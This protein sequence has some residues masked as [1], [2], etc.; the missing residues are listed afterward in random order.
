TTSPPNRGDGPTSSGWLQ[1]FQLLPLILLFIFS[2]SSSFFNSP[3][4]QYPTFSLQRHPPYT[5]QRFTHSLQI[6]YFVNPNDFNMLE[7]N[8]RI[9]RRYE[10]TVETSYVKQ[11]QQLCN[12]E[13]IL[14][15]RKLNEALGWYFNLDER[16]LEEAKEMKMPNCEK[17]NELAEIVGQAR[18]ASKF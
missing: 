14:Q 5:E 4:D 7:Q 12:S 17:L 15:K 9:L 10:E 11:L 6:P 13:K 8:P 3:Q 2:F 16:K 1:L 18:K